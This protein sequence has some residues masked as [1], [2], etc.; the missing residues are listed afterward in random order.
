MIIKQIYFLFTKKIVSRKMTLQGSWCTYLN[1]ECI[2]VECTYRIDRFNNIHG[3]T[4][5]RYIPVYSEQT[6]F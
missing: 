5:L 4:V 3:A 2:H 6:I 1:V